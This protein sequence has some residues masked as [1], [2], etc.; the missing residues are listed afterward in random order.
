[1]DAEMIEEFGLSSED[2]YKWCIGFSTCHSGDSLT[3]WPKEKVWQETERLKEQ[4]LA[5]DFYERKSDLNLKQLLEQRNDLLQALEDL[6]SYLGED[7]ESD[8]QVMEAK[9]AIQKATQP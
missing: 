3:K 1:M 9:Q 2:E 4:I 8:P 5:M 6:I 7:W